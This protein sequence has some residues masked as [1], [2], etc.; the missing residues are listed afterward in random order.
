MRNG[1]LL[2]LRAELFRVATSLIAWVAAVLTVLVS[3]LRVW[4]SVVGERIRRAEAAASGRELTSDLESGTAWPMLVDGW[5]AGLMMATALLLVA[6]AR[7]VAGDRESGLL[8]LGVTRSTSRV[9]AVVGRALVGPVLVAALVTLSGLGA[10]FGATVIGGGDFG[11]Q[12]MFGSPLFAAEEVHDSLVLALV[13]ASLGLVA[14]H[15]FGVLVSALIPG[16]LIAVA[17]ALT[18]IV[19]WDVFKDAA[20]SD[21][22]GFVF[23]TH[24]PTFADSSPMIEMVKISRGMSDGVI[25]DEVRAKGTFF[26]A[27]EAV[28]FVALACLALRRKRI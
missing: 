12:M 20:G 27:V 11:D 3:V 22:A 21:A 4:A 1:A 23:A 26:P 17:V 25:S 9:G 28:L 5:R 15:A 6:G 18:S 10:W 24:A 14:V 16:P 19:L 7:T 2:T 8:R 13:I